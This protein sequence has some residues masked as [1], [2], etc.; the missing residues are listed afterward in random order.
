MELKFKHFIILNMLD[1]ITTYIGLTY[2]HLTEVNSF[3]LGMFNNY[4]FI[5][6]LVSMKC[7]ELMLAYGILK[8]Y[9]LKIKIIILNICCFIMVA[10]IIN[11]TYQMIRVL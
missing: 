11:N 8:M 2:L 1:I 4:G 6:A 5:F 7:I 10:V 3:A 9:P